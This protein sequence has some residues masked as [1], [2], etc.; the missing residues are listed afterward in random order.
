MEPFNLCTLTKER[1][2]KAFENLKI[3]LSSHNKIIKHS[4]IMLFV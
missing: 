2:E 1:T 3:M 4:H